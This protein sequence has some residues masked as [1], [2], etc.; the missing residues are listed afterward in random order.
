MCIRDRY[1]RK[2]FSGNY[3][4][5]FDNSPLISFFTRSLGFGCKTVYLEHSVWD[6]YNAVTKLLNRITYKKVRQVVCCSEMVYRSNGCQGIVLNNAVNVSEVNEVAPSKD[7]NFDGYQVVISVANVSKV[8]NHTMLV[9][10]FGLMNTPSVKLV[11][12]GDLR[13]NYDNVQEAINK[14]S[15]KHDI[16]LYGPSDNVYGLLK[17]AD[18]FCLTS[19]FEGMPI[20]LLEAMSVG[21][22]P[23]CTNVGGIPDVITEKCGFV[24]EKGDV[25]S[26]SK[27]ID[28]ILENAKVRDVMSHESIKEIQDNY[29]LDD[30]C[31]NLMNLFKTIN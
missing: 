29:N 24:V 20:S 18:V 7:V 15:K 19:N 23:V 30:Y 25:I 28:F 5:I 22:V 31:D 6:N 10:A 11:I 21:V 3:D 2:L 17:L 12:V 26:F 1:Y 14:S 9:H 16:I 4:I 27:K 13:D 8:K